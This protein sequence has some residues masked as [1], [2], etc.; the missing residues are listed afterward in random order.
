ERYTSAVAELERARTPVQAQLAKDTAL[1]GPYYVRAAREAM[2]MDPG[3]ELPETPGQD[4]AGRVTEDRTDEEDGRQ[5]SAATAPSDHPPHCC[6]GGGV[7]GRP[8]PAGGYSGPRWPSALDSGMLMMSSVMMFNM[9]FAG[10]SG[11]GY[12]GEE[13]ASGIGEGGADMGDVGGD[14]CG[15]D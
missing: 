15:G 6:R 7:A 3:P 2:G 9:M 4:R 8:V 11:V 12:S 14:M 1:E 13:L 5:M 10:M